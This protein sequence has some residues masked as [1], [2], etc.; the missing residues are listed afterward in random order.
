MAQLEY[1]IVVAKSPAEH[2]RTGY[3]R[4]TLDGLLLGSLLIGLLLLAGSRWQLAA[5][6]GGVL[7]VVVLLTGLWKIKLHWLGLGFW[8]Q[9]TRG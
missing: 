3:L 4:G 6:V 9:R 1:P 7:I 8:P 5:V 2:E